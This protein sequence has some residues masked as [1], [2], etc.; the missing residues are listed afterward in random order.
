MNAIGMWASRGGRSSE[1]AGGGIKLTIMVTGYYDTQVKAARGVGERRKN[2]CA[3]DGGGSLL[4]KYL[5]GN[6]VRIWR[7]KNICFCS[8][9]LSGLVADGGNYGEG[10]I[11]TKSPSGGGGGGSGLILWIVRCN[12]E[13]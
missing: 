13:L 2:I 10:K 6:P 12:A 9:A 7:R 5:E 8:P 11:V 3:F 4:S 1:R